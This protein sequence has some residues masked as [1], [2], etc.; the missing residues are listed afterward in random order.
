MEAHFVN[1]SEPTLQQISTL[2]TQINK[3]INV[4]LTYT[5]HIAPLFRR[6]KTQNADCKPQFQFKLHIISVC[7]SALNHA[8]LTEVA[9]QL[10]SETRMTL[11]N[12]L[13]S[14]PTWIHTGT[15]CRHSAAEQIFCSHTVQYFSFHFLVSDFDAGPSQS[16]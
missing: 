16:Q 9:G 15:T 5:Q 13:T 11:S 3:M 1:T 14:S 4:T 10:K 12:T 2:K 7:A 8:P 6:R